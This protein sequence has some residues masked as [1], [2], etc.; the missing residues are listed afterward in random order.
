MD[1][2]VQSEVIGND[3]DFSEYG[4]FG[5]GNIPNSI[6]EAL[7]ELDNQFKA[8]NF[9]EAL[10]EYIGLLPSNIWQPYED[11]SGIREGWY[12]AYY[13]GFPIEDLTIKFDF[14]QDG[15][16]E[17]FRVRNAHLST[18]YLDSP[19]FE[20]NY[21]EQEAL[22]LAIQYVFNNQNLDLIPSNTDISGYEGELIDSVV[23]NDMPIYIFRIGVNN[24]YQTNKLINEINATILALESE[25]DVIIAQINSLDGIEDAEQIS[26]L[27]HSTD[28]IQRQLLDLEQSLENIQNPTQEDALINADIIDS[29]YFPLYEI[30]V[31]VSDG[32]ASLRQPLIVNAAE[33]EEIIQE[34]NNKLSE[35]NNKNLNKTI[36]N[37]L[38]AVGLGVGLLYLISSK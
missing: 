22:E 15:S 11:G 4:V 33:S 32:S 17:D 28:S 16:I 38:I 8:E 6:E 30:N 1:I 20:I 21:T 13:Q 36:N 14:R 5:Y 23:Q 26:D 12:Q 37:N 7:V 24:E 34:N 25:W 3:N 10:Q 9:K 35:L 29:S 27:N 2:S 19:I 18:I 31:N